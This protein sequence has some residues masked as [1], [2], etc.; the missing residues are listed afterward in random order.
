MW[1]IEQDELSK[2][3]IPADGQENC[4]AE[5]RMGQDVF[6]PWVLSRQTLEKPGPDRTFKTCA[7]LRTSDLISPEQPKSPDV[8]NRYY[9]LFSQ[10]ELVDLASSAATELGLEVGLPPLSK[11]DSAN[12]KTRGVTIVQHG[13]ERSNYYVELQCWDC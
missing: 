12:V 10:G 5:S 7:N 3:R 6:V 1:A 8:V 13:W 9:H 11:V 2:R 4:V